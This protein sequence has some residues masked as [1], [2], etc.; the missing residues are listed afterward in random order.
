[1]KVA[2]KQKGSYDSFQS[3]Q[4]RGE[5]ARYVKIKVHI[6]V[7]TVCVTMERVL[8]KGLAESY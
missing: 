3:K 1:M 2:A 7:I 6:G 4:K 5:R 8:K